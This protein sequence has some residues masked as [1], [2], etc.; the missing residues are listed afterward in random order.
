MGIRRRLTGV[1]ASCN[2]TA[3]MFWRRESYHWEND[4]LDTWWKCSR[5]SKLKGESMT[6]KKSGDFWLFCKHCTAAWSLSLARHGA[7][8]LLV[9]VKTGAWMHLKQLPLWSQRSVYQQQKDSNKNPNPQ[10]NGLKQILMSWS[11]YVITQPNREW[12]TWA[13]VPVKRSLSNKGNT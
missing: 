2:L 5:R 11:G 1:Y 6:T 12:R 8:M 9:K 3:K 4:L 10:R 7:E 13:F